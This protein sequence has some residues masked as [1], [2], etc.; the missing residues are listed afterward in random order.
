MRIEWGENNKVIR[1]IPENG[2]ESILLNLAWQ[3]EVETYFD[4]GNNPYL[5]ITLQTDSGKEEMNG[6]PK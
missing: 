1:L 5:E 2:K 3:P 6:T 4:Q